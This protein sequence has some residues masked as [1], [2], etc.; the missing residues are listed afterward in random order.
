MKDVTAGTPSRTGDIGFSHIQVKLPPCAPNSNVGVIHRY[1]EPVKLRGD[2]ELAA[3]R[4]SDIASASQAS[5]FIKAAAAV[6]LRWPEAQT[7]YPKS[8]RIS[9]AS[10]AKV[11]SFPDP[12][13]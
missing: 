6:V 4:V 13:Y 10:E 11:A 9:A 2:D 3:P 8:S 5:Y 7:G 1:P 12:P